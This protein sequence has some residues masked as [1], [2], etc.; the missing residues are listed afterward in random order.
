MK[1]T[2]VI[3]AVILLATVNLYAAPGDVYVEG[4]LGV[5]TEEPSDG[6]KAD[7]DGAVGATQYCDQNGG[8]CATPPLQQRVTVT[9]NASNQKIIAINQNGTVQCGT[10]NTDTSTHIQGGLYGFCEESR[11]GNFSCCINMKFPTGCVDN[12][13]M[14]SATCICPSGYTRIQMGGPVYSC[15]KD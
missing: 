13:T 14:S 4:T 15:Y 2:L 8:N 7:V 9:C 12:N 3:R 6:L 11:C 5:G 1:K 10:D